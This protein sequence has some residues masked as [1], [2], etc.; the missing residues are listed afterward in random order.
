MDSRP[1]LA[2]VEVD[3]AHVNDEDLLSAAGKALDALEKRL[4]TLTGVSAKPP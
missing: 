1:A 2:S 4:S 3:A